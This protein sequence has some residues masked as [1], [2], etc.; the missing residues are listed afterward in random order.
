[1]GMPVLIRTRIHHTLMPFRWLASSQCVHY[2]TGNMDGHDGRWWNNFIRDVHYNVYVSWAS[3]CRTR[4]LILISTSFDSS[5]PPLPLSLSFSFSRS[6]RSVSYLETFI[7]QQ[8]VQCRHICAV[9]LNSIYTQFQSML[10][11]LPIYSILYNTSRMYYA[12]DKQQSERW[13]EA[14]NKPMRLQWS[15]FALVDRSRRGNRIKSILFENGLKIEMYALISI[16]F[17][18]H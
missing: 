16:Y 11:L 9:P 13:K 3:T 5:C 1:M 12:N 10:L 2:N 15:I 4:I 8:E 6:L 18:L 14:E 17:H 7:R